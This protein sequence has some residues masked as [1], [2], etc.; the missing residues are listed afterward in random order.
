MSITNFGSIYNQP[1]LLEMT[2]LTYQPTVGDR[3]IPSMHIGRC[4][5]QKTAQ[6]L[7]KT[8]QLGFDRYLPGNGAQIYRTDLVNFHFQPAK[9]PN[10]CTSFRW[11]QLLN[12]HNPA[13]KELVDR[14][15]FSSSLVMPR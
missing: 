8:R 3:L 1:Y 15:V 5:S 10:A 9:I 4:I 6:A 12:S 13:M 7:Y 11:L 2:R 14:H